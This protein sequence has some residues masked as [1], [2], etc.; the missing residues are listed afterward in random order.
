MMRS[1]LSV[2][3]WMCRFVVW[4]VIATG[5]AWWIR[6]APGLPVVDFD[7]DWLVWIGCGFAVWMVVRVGR[8]PWRKAVTHE[9]KLRWYHKLLARIPVVGRIGL[10]MA[11]MAQRIGIEHGV[12]HGWARCLEAKGSKKRSHKRQIQKAIEEA[13]VI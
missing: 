5:L 10:V 1:R 2:L 3:W 9:T 12:K 8:S 13:R 4:G 6:F 7:L 11:Q